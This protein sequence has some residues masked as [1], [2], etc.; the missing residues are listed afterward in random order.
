MKRE[1]TECFETSEYNIQTPGNYAEE[2]IQYT[3]HGES[4]KSRIP[5]NLL[6]SQAGVIWLVGACCL[7]LLCFALLGWLISLSV[8]SFDFK[9][10]WQLLK[11]HRRALI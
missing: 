9:L 6:A 11:P 2:N 1:Q 5:E 4:L 3:K 7:S 8:R 10:F